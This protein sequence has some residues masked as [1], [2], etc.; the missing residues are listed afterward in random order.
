MKQT[1]SSN[2]LNKMSADAFLKNYW[3]KKPLLIRNALSNTTSLFNADE[4]AGLA[5][6]EDV[7]SRII[8]QRDGE[9]K[10]ELK[11]G[12]FNEKVFSSLPE[13]HWTLLVQAVDHYIPEASKLINLFNFIPRWRIDDLMV[14]YASNGGGV[15]PHFDNYDVFLVQTNGKR[16]WEI[17][18]KCNAN[19]PLD[20][21]LPVT[22]L[23]EFEAQDSWIL[24]AGDMLYLPPSY[25]H[26][27]VAMSND[28]ITCSVGFRAPSHSEVLREFTD[29]IGD[30]LSEALRYQD[31][32]LKQQH[33]IGEI[34]SQTIEK[35]QNI[36]LA[37]CN[38]EKL[39]REW[40]G[41][42]ITTPKYP[43]NHDDDAT[44]IET[45]ITIEH[46]NKH[47]SIGGSLARNESSRLA[48]EKTNN[49]LTF[50]VDG[51]HIDSKVDSKD[52]IETLCSCHVLCKK[53]FIQSENNLKLLLT[54]LHNG[55]LYLLE[56]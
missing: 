24:E 14:S 23:S 48:F 31:P 56:T 10:W 27:G 52:L 43:K 38:D 8:I 16:K 51:N 21:N 37:Y 1:T 13:T 29:Y 6:E 33:N 17:G 28:C 22:I 55:S 25:A 47:L 18:G 5:Y 39:I 45:T 20:R 26:N 35:L 7:E 34:S 3:Q 32:D 50:Y 19:T 42:Y 4:L 53:D 12:P 30:N 54:L 44:N 40:F 49:K 15:G 36:L 9:A 11:H 2:P 41:H 46:L